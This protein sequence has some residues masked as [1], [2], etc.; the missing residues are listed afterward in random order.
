MQCKQKLLV[1]G[2]TIAVTCTVAT[3][4]QYI[5][6]KVYYTNICGTLDASFNDPA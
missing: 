1:P 5:L 6:C 4:W 3:K 2:F